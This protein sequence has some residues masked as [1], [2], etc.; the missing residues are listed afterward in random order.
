MIDDFTIVYYIRPIHWKKQTKKGILVAWL[1]APSSFL[2]IRP[3]TGRGHHPNPGAATWDLGPVKG[4]RL[5]DEWEHVE[6]EM[7]LTWSHIRV[8]KFMHN[9]VSY[10]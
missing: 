9:I 8:Y 6:N 1:T 5:D 3:S 7:F 4:Q 10:L 2:I